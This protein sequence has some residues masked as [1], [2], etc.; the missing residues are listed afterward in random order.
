MSKFVKTV[1]WLTLFIVFLSC[2]G[3]QT[4]EPKLPENVEILPDTTLGPGDV[5]D[6]RVYGEDDLSSTFRVASDGT[7]DYPLLGSVQVLGMTPT[8]VVSILETRLVE[9]EFLKKPQVSVFV[10][11]Y[12][13]KK[14][15]ILGEVKK[16]GTFLYQDGMSVVEAISLAGGFTAMAR[17]NDTTV[18]RVVKGK[19]TRFRV[20]VEE[21]GQGKAANFFLRS[22]DILFVPKRVF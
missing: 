18:I 2:G 9:G 7:I 4:S 16:P 20:P 8:E 17:E 13:S 19:K 1:L 15:S 6:V 10:K 14:I 22:G 5:F 12:K 11:E 21:I 3:N